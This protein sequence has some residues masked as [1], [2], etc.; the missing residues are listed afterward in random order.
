MNICINIFIVSL[1]NYLV[2][3]KTD[4]QV[5]YFCVLITSFIYRKICMLT[6]VLAKNGLVMNIS[7]NYHVSPC[8]RIDIL[9]HC[10][11]ACAH[12]AIA[13]DRDR[14]L[15]RAQCYC[16]PNDSIC[17]LTIHANRE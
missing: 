3:F 12:K 10:Q 9:S 2:L 17:E 4:R 13:I 6:F 1:D 15:L 16:A 14:S 7:R 5:F 11:R 8:I